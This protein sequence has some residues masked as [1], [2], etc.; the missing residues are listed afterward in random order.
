MTAQPITPSRR[1]AG[2]PAGGQFSPAPRPESATDLPLPGDADF[3]PSEADFADAGTP[4]P[5][6]V[7]GTAAWDNASGGDAGVYGP[8]DDA[9]DPDLM[10]SIGEDRWFRSTRAGN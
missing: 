2:S 7:Y 9:A 6:Y 8:D 10:A 4:P 5:R 3:A 1:P